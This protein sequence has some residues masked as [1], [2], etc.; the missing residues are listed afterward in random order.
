[1]SLMVSVDVK[2]HFFYFFY[3]P[4]FRAQELCESR[5]GGGGGDI[6]N[7]N[8]H[9]VPVMLKAF[10][11]SMPRHFHN[12]SS[13]SSLNPESFSKVYDSNFQ[14]SPRTG[15]FTETTSRF[16]ESVPHLIPTVTGLPTKWKVKLNQERP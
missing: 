15:K 14:L 1:M 4:V 9:G 8:V 10:S 13:S 11:F 6:K 5:D 16:R 12:F 2:H 7:G 3:W